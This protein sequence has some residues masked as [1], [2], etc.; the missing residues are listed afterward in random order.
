MGFGST[1]GHFQIKLP[2][3]DFTDEVVQCDVPVENLYVAVIY[4]WSQI[5]FD[6]NT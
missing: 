5:N 1:K 6:V 2:D 4:K 3:I